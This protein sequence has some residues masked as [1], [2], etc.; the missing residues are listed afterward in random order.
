M[1][2][3]FFRDRLVVCVKLLIPTESQEQITLIKW[4]RL[5]HPDHR[6]VASAN[7]GARNVITATRMKKEGVSA[8][9]P[10]LLVPSLGL[11]IELKRIKGGVV[12]AEQKDWLEY[13]RGCGYRAEVCN[14][15]DA[16]RLVIENAISLYGK[17]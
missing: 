5:A 11:F 9:Y 3:D 2:G 17:L 6:I 10:D 7:G 13:L 15:F 14:G 1:V 16:A 4:M 12:S 8:G